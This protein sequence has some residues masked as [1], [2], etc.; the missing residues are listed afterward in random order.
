LWEKKN[1]DADAK[2]CQTIGSMKYWF[3]IVAI[4]LSTASA[5]FAQTT[6]VYKRDSL[7]NVLARSK[8]DTAKVLAMVRLGEL[9]LNDHPDSAEYYA[10]AFGLL[11][12]KLNFA[13][14]KAYSLSM[15]AFVSVRQNRKDEA[16]AMDLEAIEILKKTDRKKAL[17]NLY[18][19]TAMI[20]SANSDFS[21][22][23]DLYLKAEAIYEQLN[24]SSSLA[25]M[26]G[27]LATI[28]LDLMEYRSAYL[29]SLKSVLLCRSLRQTMG[30]GAGLI[31]LASSLVNLQRFD[32]ALVVLNDSRD[33]SKRYDS[34]E[35][36]T[37]ALGLINLVY[38]GMGKFDLLRNNS[39][40]LIAAARS[41]ADSE[42]VCN[43]MAGLV[44]YYLHEKK[45][46]MAAYYSRECIRIAKGD[47]LALT[48]RDAY[49]AAARIEIEK[50]NIA[51][52]DL[53]N[54]L[55]DSI[56]EAI[57]SEKIVRNTQE[58][59]AK[60]SLSKKQGEIDSLNKEKKIQQLIL[61]QR[62]TI[63]W[64]LGGVVLVALL[65]GFLYQRSYRQQKQLL[66]AQAVL[67][68]QVEERTRLAKDLHDGLGSILSSAKFSFNNMKQNL[69]ISPENAAAFEKSMDML[70]KSIAELRRVAHNMMPETLMKFGLDTALKDFCSTVDQSGAVKLTYQ[71]FGLEETTV[72]EI[73][74]AAVYRIV[75]ELVNNILKHA[76][77]TSALVQLISKDGTLSITV[78][79]NGRGFERKVLET[80]VGIG[81]SSLQNRVTYLKGTI[82]LQTSPGKGTALHIQLPNLN[83]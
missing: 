24:D 51:G 27:N 72:P 63:N 55:R 2:A 46:P 35:A 4:I 56:D 18:N 26:Y 11:S 42:G 7:L 1:V 15:R 29:Y 45:Y 80:G 62:N 16:I 69:I 61:R 57:R 40:A 13:L 10:K 71:S 74:S 53:Y 66:A 38:I 79:D 8:E 33:L 73:T 19:N 82:E 52:F 75:Q 14:G 34:V 17:A 44:Q 43:G 77:A 47:S 5:L 65:I 64:V 83:A 25:F 70:D 50:G 49:I 41:F 9:Y 20:Y 12:E 48:L 76:G 54:E 68:G 60:Y 58:L 6:R 67:Q 36:N 23:L 28:D 31:N 22:S 59:E 3:F 21:E 78:E 30:L 81:Y 37:R 39:I 32:T